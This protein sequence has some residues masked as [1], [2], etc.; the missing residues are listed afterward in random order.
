MR[1]FLSSISSFLHNI[2]DLSFQLQLSLLCGCCEIAILVFMGCLVTKPFAT[3]M[4]L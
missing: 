2:K 1:F 4:H 3:G